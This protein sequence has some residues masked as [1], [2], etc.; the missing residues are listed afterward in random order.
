MT[1]GDVVSIVMY[2][3]T[4]L[5]VV[6][7]LVHRIDRLTAEMREMHDE[8][9]RA[10]AWRRDQVLD[11][12]PPADVPIDPNPAADLPRMVALRRPK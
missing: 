12:A 11:P 10:T 1:L 2:G 6:K 7:L 8:L 5:W 4:L 9:A 3:V